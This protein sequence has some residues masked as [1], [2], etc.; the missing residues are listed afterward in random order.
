[1]KFKSQKG[2]VALFVLIALLFYMGFLLLL[3]ANNLNKIQSISEKIEFIKSIYE[4][5]VNNI[6]DVY[7]RRFAQNDNKQPI[8][9]DIPTKIITNNIPSIINNVTKLEDSY[10]EY[11]ALGGKTEYIA[12]N[13]T[14]SSLTEVVQYATANNLYGDCNIEINA[15]GNNKK[16]STKKQTIEIL[17]GAEVKNEND[18][19]LALSV[20]E[21]L[22]IRIEDNIECTNSID[23][24]NVSHKLDLNNKIISITKENESFHFIT[25]GSNANLTITDSSIEKNGTI[26]TKLFQEVNSDGETRTNTITGIRNYGTLTIE[27]GKVKADLVQKMLNRRDGTTVEDTCSAIENAGIVNLNG[28]TIESNIETQGAVYLVVKKAKAN[29]RGIT[30]TGTVNLNSGSII[31]NAVA[32]V[33]RVTGAT[34]SGKT[35]A[36]AY[37]ILG[38]GKINDSNNV[39]F[40]TKATA[41]T[42]GTYYTD[43]DN[44]N[45]AENSKVAIDDDDK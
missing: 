40:I 43:S 15:Y 6:D 3:Y 44:L 20:T 18:L 29:G 13:T 5:N 11:G 45:M 24:N 36:Y 10:E 8:I 27:S 35:Y 7:N 34:V 17:K 16:E 25:V 14:F 31:T 26:L 42:S 4:K 41:N 37:G 30:N 39:T 23:I 32:S 19:N 1:M 22:Y 2:S 33:I 12:F 9:K 28:G 38:S 21:S